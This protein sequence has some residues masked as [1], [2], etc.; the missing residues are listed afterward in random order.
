MSL[1]LIE[2]RLST[3]RSGLTPSREALGPRYATK[4]LALKLVLC[5]GRGASARNPPSHGGP[6]IERSSALVLGDAS[7]K[8]AATDAGLPVTVGLTQGLGFAGVHTVA[9]TAHA[10]ATKEMEPSAWTGSVCRILSLSLL[11]A[12]SSKDIA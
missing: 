8:S 1:G 7:G 12:G 11:L 10:L 2:C 5:V 4:R 9:R 6:G 3:K